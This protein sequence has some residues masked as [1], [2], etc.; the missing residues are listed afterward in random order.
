MGEDL[1]L[2]PLGLA[3][4]PKLVDRPAEQHQLVWVWLPLPVEGRTSHGDSQLLVQS[5][6]VARLDFR[7]PW[8]LWDKRKTLRCFVVSLYFLRAVS[9]RPGRVREALLK[10]LANKQFPLGVAVR[11]TALGQCTTDC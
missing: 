3:L 1:G 5:W 9:F 10:A 11:K 6:P 8:W 4:L 7:R 2:Q